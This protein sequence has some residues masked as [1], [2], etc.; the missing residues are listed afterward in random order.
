MHYCTQ[1]IITHTHNDQ[2]ENHTELS[3]LNSHDSTATLMVH[4]VN[5]AIGASPN[6]S[7]V[8]QIFS[9]EVVQLKNT[10]SYMITAFIENLLKN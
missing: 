8:S 3:H 1:C 2:N 10:T 5:G 6:F 7:L 9:C 4:L